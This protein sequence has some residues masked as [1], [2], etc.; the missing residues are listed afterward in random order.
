MPKS[1]WNWTEMLCIRK[2]GQTPYTPNTNLLYGLK[3][4]LRI[5]NEEGM[6]KRLRPAY[7]LR[8]GNPEQR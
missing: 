3:E 6:D 5:L 1:F 8:R 2:N 4:A 7:P